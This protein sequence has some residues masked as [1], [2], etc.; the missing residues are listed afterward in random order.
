MIPRK[1]F[2]AHADDIRGELC[3]DQSGVLELTIEIMSLFAQQ[4]KYID[5][6]PF[7][8]QTP[9]NKPPFILFMLI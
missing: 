3:R 5:L 4:V 8:H 6:P 9:K 2:S 1:C 7:G